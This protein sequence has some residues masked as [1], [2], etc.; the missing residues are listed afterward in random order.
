[1]SELTLDETIK[2]LRQHKGHLV[3]CKEVLSK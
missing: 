2:V 3:V 1:M